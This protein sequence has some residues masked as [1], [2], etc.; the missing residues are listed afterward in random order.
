M[1]LTKCGHINDH[2]SKMDGLTKK[3]ITKDYFGFLVHLLFHDYSGLMYVY[4]YMMSCYSSQKIKEWIGY[5]IFR[6]SLS[7]FK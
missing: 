1:P 5:N 3:R 6:C 2:G 7:L 4:K